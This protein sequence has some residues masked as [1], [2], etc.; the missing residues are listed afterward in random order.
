MTCREFLRL[1]DEDGP[2]DRT[3]AAD[4]VSTCA[5]CRRA[6]E[7]WRAMKSAL[8][9]MN[10]DPLPPFLH[11]RL[12]DGI[13]AKRAR[14]S[15][16][17][18]APMARWLAPLA[19][20]GVVA[21]IVGHEAWRAPTHPVLAPTPAPT[22]PDCQM[23]PA[24]RKP[25]S[26][27]TRRTPVRTSVKTE[28]ATAGATGEAKLELGTD[29][30][31]SMA[32]A[33]PPTNLIGS[34]G[35]SFAPE[36]PG[37]QESTG[38]APEKE[39]RADPT[40]KIEEAKRHKGSEKD[41]AHRDYEGGIRDA[42]IE[43]ALPMPPRAAPGARETRVL[44]ILRRGRNEAR[45]QTIACFLYPVEAPDSPR[46]LELPTETAPPPGAVWR[47]DVLPDGSIRLEDAKPARA[48][49]PASRA[50]LDDDA[51]KTKQ[52]SAVSEGLALDDLSRASEKLGRLDS[53]RSLP[54]G[55]Y[56][57]RRAHTER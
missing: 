35:D 23:T 12:M 19:V 22:N 47:L 48:S 32:R 49:E 55:R 29:H 3:P 20:I 18:L 28:H 11:T 30:A 15:A 45:S 5:S 56:L 54:R 21:M 41:T 17:A 37:I 34:G 4:H 9:S 24:V 13:K 36:V 57:L 53:I 10:D 51:R 1:L 33:A 43:E 52:R 25:D 6:L 27:K 26:D 31:P 2:V 14:R 7:R 42:P 46:S 50:L 40:L 38:T 8:A 16:W 44:G 39:M